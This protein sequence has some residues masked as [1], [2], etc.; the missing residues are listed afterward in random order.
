MENAMQSHLYAEKEL[1]AQTVYSDS[2]AE[3]TLPD[4]LPEMRRVLSVRTEVSP[5]GQYVGQSRAEFAGTC[6][7][8]VLY[9]DAQGQVWAPPFPRILSLPCRFRGQTLPPS[10]AMRI[11]R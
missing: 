3:Y 5:S 10:S 2:T 7:H 9:T 1:Q 11:T 4:Y 6:M 8:R